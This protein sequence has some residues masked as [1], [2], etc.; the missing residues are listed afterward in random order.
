VEHVLCV[1]LKRLTAVH[2]QLP[3]RPLL[4][5]HDVVRC[6]VAFQ[7]LC[8]A[9][10]GGICVSACWHVQLLRWSVLCAVPLQQQVHAVATHQREHRACMGTPSVD[11]CSGQ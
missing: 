9:W 5:C 4:V 1:Y 10:M 11:A 2:V 6:I 3:P 8:A 7:V